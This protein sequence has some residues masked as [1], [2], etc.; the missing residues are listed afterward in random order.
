MEQQPSLPTDPLKPVN[1]PTNWFLITTVGLVAVIFVLSGAVFYLWQ[2][3][4]QP[5]VS[6]TGNS[7]KPQVLVTHNP[8]AVVSPQPTSTLDQVQGDQQQAQPE[9][10]V[11][12]DW[13]PAWVPI[14]EAKGQ[15]TYTKRVKAGKIMDGKYKNFDLN[16]EMVQELG[17]SYRHYV[18]DNGALVYFDDAKV[19]IKIRGIDDLPETIELPGTSYTLKK[20]WIAS[21]PYSEIKKDFKI[22]TDPKLGDVYLTDQGCFV[23]ELPDHT[24]VS[25]DLVIPFVNKDTRALQVVFGDGATNA[26]PYT[27][28]RITGCGALCMYLAK[29]DETV[30][31]P[32]ARLAEAGKTSNGEALYAFIDTNAKEL[33]TLYN[34]KN[35]VA[36]YNQNGNYEQLP[37]SKYTYAQFLQYH[38]L[39][40]WKDPLGRWIE[41]KNDRFQIAA[42]M[43]KPVIYLYPQKSTDVTVQVAPNGGFSFTKPVYGSGWHVVAYPDGSI[44]NIADG[45]HYPYLFWEGIGLN[46]PEQDSGFVVDAANL[47]SFLSEKL[48]ALGL[49]GKEVSDFKDYWT[50]RLQGLHKPYYQ[51]TFLKKEQMDE[52]APLKLSVNPNSV[53]R[54]MMTAKGLNEYKDIPEQ[55]LPVPAERLG[56]TVVEWGGTVLR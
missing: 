6:E 22:F 18:D 40:Y 12:V 44:K 16:I 55:Q 28:T 11:N 8:D 17:T 56:F 51:I 24:A 23:V 33:K 3:N 29:M 52:L 43:C 10:Y 5:K 25:Y 48:A 35:T 30:L 31:Q 4:N 36:Y 47:G 53:I 34:D 9:S 32:Q 41:F 54:V 19:N 7:L 13:L 26:D 14:P 49:R 46:Y 38:P 2:K 20:N 37:Q 1:K 42:E 50:P 39:L 27:Y 45:K 21:D 15:D